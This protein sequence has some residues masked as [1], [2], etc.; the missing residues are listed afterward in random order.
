MAF[1]RP[2]NNCSGGFTLVE[3]LVVIAVIAIL[4]ALLLPALAAAKA[5][6]HQVACLNNMKQLS[7]GLN[8]YIHDHEDTFPPIQERLPDG[9]T[10]T[11]WRPYLFEYVGR[12]PHV[13]DCAAE[14]K[15]VYANGNRS[16]VG[17]FRL[18]EIAIPS[19]IGAVNV[20]WQRNGAQPP[21]GRPAGDGYETN[22]CKWNMVEN[23]SVLIVFGDGHS[24]I[25][26]TWPYDRWWIWKFTAANSPGFNRATQRDPG[27][28]RHS[29]K[30]NYARADGSASLLD[31]NRILCTTSFCEWS[32]KVD[33]H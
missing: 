25:D 7:I 21:F 24:D 5:K 17:Q 16:L 3:L 9:F 27:A 6:A 14:K 26:G 30:S 11:S 22:I 28:F 32:A 13:Y 10:E 8:L 15:E 18:G 2:A 33:P 4:A 29:R 1:R 23:Y 12:V 31:P 19:G 20:H